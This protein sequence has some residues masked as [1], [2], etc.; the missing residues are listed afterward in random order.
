MSNLRFQVVSEAFKKKPLA[1][2]PQDVATSTYYGKNVFGRAQM[3]QY[4]SQQVMQQIC[5]SIDNGEPLGR[6]IADEVAEGMKKW[7]MDMGAT[8]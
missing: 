1:V 5:A 7:A 3:A 2:T 8:H 4:L 6:E